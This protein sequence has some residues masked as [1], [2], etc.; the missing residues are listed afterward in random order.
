MNE[1]NYFER[2]EET[3]D[4]QN[5]IRKLLKQDID[6]KDRKKLEKYRE[7]LWSFESRCEEAIGNLELLMPESKIQERRKLI[8]QKEGLEFS[9]F[10]QLKKGLS[11]EEIPVL[12]DMLQYPEEIL[13]I[14]IEDIYL[15]YHPEEE[16]IIQS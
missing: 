16:S 14:M 2:F 11:E 12:E 13:Y 15:R 9:L 8:A 4:Y 6:E 3:L 5:M 1:K 10:E 7:G